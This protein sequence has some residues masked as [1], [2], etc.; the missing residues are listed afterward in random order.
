M[1]V[2]L[3]AAGLLL[4]GTEGSRF[5]PLFVSGRLPSLQSNQRRL[6][7]TLRF[8]DK[9]LEHLHPETDYRQAA[10]L[11]ALPTPVDPWS[12]D[13]EALTSRLFSSSLAPYLAFLWFLGRPE[14][15]T[16]PLALF[17]F[18]FLL[19]F[20]FSTIPAGIY[21]KTQYG[22]KLA[23]V[24]WLHGGS[25]AFLCI[26]NL[27]IVLGMRRALFGD[28]GAE[29]S[30]SSSGGDGA[31][32]EEERGSLWDPPKVERGAAKR[33]DTVARF[34]ALSG[35]QIGREGT[36]RR[37]EDKSSV[38]RRLA[39]AWGGPSLGALLLTGGG[40]AMAAAAAGESGGGPQSFSEIG[41]ALLTAAGIDLLREEP[42]NA[43][44]FPTW[45]IHSSSVIEWLVAMGLVW[46]WG[47]RRDERGEVINPRWKGLTWA[48]VPLHSS[49]LVA[50]TYHI[51]FNPK[52]LD[53]LVPLQA[54]LTLLGDALCA[55][56]AYRVWSFE[57]E[58]DSRG[59]VGEG[60]SEAVG[61][62]RE[63]FE[64]PSSWDT[65]GLLGW[66]DLGVG[67]QGDGDAVFFGKA[68]AASVAVAALIKYGELLVDFPFEPSYAYALPLFGVP[69]ALNVLKWSRKS[70]A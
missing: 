28:G 70:A 21:A 36:S 29:G 18:R 39:L 35:V 41:T 47:E 69:T 58:K 48:M 53:A 5:N 67:L 62:G 50:C 31:L 64:I 15:K 61:F 42:Y 22:E 14:T 19:V 32:Q 24:D 65:G 44:S 33:Q 52:A 45:T 26:T 4:A 55:F 17:G 1:R 30:G 43:L 10:A 20:V 25:E 66:E 7:E 12:V 60:N 8:S 59:G 40:A 57:R 49:G 51:F 38:W 9:R 3:L 56:A 46:Q 68:L 11:G 6:R 13:N 2:A 27:I 37:P 16:P 63:K 34:T 23:N 54:G